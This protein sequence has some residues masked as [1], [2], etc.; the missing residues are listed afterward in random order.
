MIVN[1]REAVPQAIR[2]NTDPY[3]NDLLNGIAEKKLAAGLKEQAGYTRSKL[4]G[5][6]K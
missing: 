5:A 1:L 4:P 2:S 3:I 6:N